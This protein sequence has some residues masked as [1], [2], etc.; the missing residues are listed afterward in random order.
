MSGLLRA[1]KM[2]KQKSKQCGWRIEEALARKFAGFCAERGWNQ[3]R[4]VEIA[5]REWLESHAKRRR[6]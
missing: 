4:Q 5:L 6:K 3:N 2:K 1:V